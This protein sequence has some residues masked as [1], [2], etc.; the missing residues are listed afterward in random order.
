M[1]C[2]GWVYGVGLLKQL[3][4]RDKTDVG[5]VMGLVCHNYIP[6]LGVAYCRAGRGLHILGYGVL[7]KR[8]TSLGCSIL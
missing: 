1:Q 5:K 6:L 7:L 2:R 4:I 3:Q 8:H